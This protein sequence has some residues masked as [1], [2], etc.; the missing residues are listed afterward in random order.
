VIGLRAKKMDVEDS[1]YYLSGL[2]GGLLIG[3]IIGF[4]LAYMLIYVSSR[5][6]QPRPT[7]VVFNRDQQGNIVSITYV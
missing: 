5:L 4:A 3:I 7:S 6:I 1:F 2:S